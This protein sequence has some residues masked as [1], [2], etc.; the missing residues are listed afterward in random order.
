MVKK[1]TEI[2][3]KI[4]D[5]NKYEIVLLAAQRARE[6]NKEKA[7]KEKNMEKALIPERKVTSIAIDEVLS[8]KVKHKYPTPE[9]KE[10]EEKKEKVRPRGLKEVY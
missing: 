5:L 2:E 9:E 6:I 10:E 7:L 1:G 3:H 8:G 4:E